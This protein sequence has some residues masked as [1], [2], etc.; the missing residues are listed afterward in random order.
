MEIQT[1]F[2]EQSVCLWRDLVIS[3]VT[4]D[5]VQPVKMRG[6]GT[7]QRRPSHVHSPRPQCLVFP[8][9]VS[10]LLIRSAAFIMAMLSTSEQEQPLASTP[11]RPHA[12]SNHLAAS[13]MSP[14]RFSFSLD[15]DPEPVPLP[16]LE[17][18]PVAEALS[19]DGSPVRPDAV[20]SLDW[21]CS[22]RRF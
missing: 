5:S 7:V 21:M 19:V 11:P 3:C 9:I 15:V 1:P 4:S 6:E 18:S 20:R 12:T 10:V 13:I 16:V 2:D 8:C 14:L 22:Q 17:L